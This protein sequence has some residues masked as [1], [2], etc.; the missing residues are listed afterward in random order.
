MWPIVLAII[1]S[2]AGYTYLRLAYAKQQKAHEPFADRQHRADQAQLEQAGWAC[3]D[4]TYHA[5]SAPTATA[6]APVVAVSDQPELVA[7][8]RALT[9]ENWIL[10]I[11]Y[12][13]LI[14]PAATA[15]T[16]AGRIAVSASLDQA[17]AQ[18]SGF[19]LYRK[20]RELIAIPRW[21]PLTGAFSDARPTTAGTIAFPAGALPP[22]RY[23]I[24][25]PALKLSN[26][27]E[28]VVTGASD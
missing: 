13:A 21:A 26:R 22:G 20:D 5:A 7:E 15:N 10:P 11:E 4:A 27:A 24:T 18:V 19:D 6:A 17:R 1:V 8:L 12:T 14:V 28:F 23:T 3:I 16:E 25:F 2:L 9:A